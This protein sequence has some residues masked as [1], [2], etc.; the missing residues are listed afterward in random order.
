MSNPISPYK[1]L[2]DGLASA[3]QYIGIRAAVAMTIRRMGAGGRYVRFDHQRDLHRLVLSPYMAWW[4]AEAVARHE[5]GHA[6]QVERLGS[7]EA[8]KDQWLKEL[9]SAGLRVGM[10]FDDPGVYGAYVSMP[11]E[12]E[13]NR[14]VT[15]VP[16]T[17]RVTSWR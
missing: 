14:I 3:A 2:P 16:Y 1:I 10:S 11:L 5:L 12:A 6:L 9:R 4:Q 8:F 15:E 13:A 7:H 17:I